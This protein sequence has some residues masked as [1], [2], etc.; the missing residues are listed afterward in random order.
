MWCGGAETRTQNH[1]AKHENCCPYSSLKLTIFFWLTSRLCYNSICHHRRLMKY[2]RSVLKLE[3]WSTFQYDIK[4]HIKTLF[5]ILARGWF[6]LGMKEHVS[7]LPP[8]KKIIQRIQNGAHFFA[9]PIIVMTKSY[10]KYKE[11]SR[12]QSTSKWCIRYKESSYPCLV[13]DSTL[14][15]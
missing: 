6:I 5:S 7:P 8:V 2:F 13:P 1:E 3:R 4:Q 9:A 10:S 15:M 11:C 12:N 14:Q